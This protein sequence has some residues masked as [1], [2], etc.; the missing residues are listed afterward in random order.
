MSDK[1][2][3]ARLLAEEGLEYFERFGDAGDK[4]Y[5]A[6]IRAVFAAQPEQSA[7]LVAWAVLGTDAG[8]TYIREFIHSWEGPNDRYAQPIYTAPP[9]PS[10]EPVAWGAFYVGGRRR[11]RLHN[12]C[13]TEDQIKAY[14]ADRHQSDDS[15]TFRAQ[16]LYTSPPAPSVPPAVR[17]AIA[18]LA[19][20]AC[21]YASLVGRKHVATIDA[22]LAA[23]PE[24]PKP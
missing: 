8:R 1:M 17:Q 13:D 20:V 7:E 22:W 11:G 16:P 23:A 24:A 12:H 15:N 2:R 14:I 10:A 18:S 9:A 3:E 6:A 21:E 4:K 19:A 5:V